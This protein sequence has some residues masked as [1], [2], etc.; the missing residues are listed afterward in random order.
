MSI[1]AGSCGSPSAPACSSSVARSS[2]LPVPRTFTCKFSV[3]DSISAVPTTISRRSKSGINCT[4]KRARSNLAIG[5][6][7]NPGALPILV[8]PTSIAICGNRSSEISPS[9]ISSRPVE[10][11]T[12]VAISSRKSLGSKKTKI[13]TAERANNAMRP[14]KSQARIL[15]NRPINGL[16]FADNQGYQNPAQKSR[17]A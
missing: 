12:A 11:L 16:L 7:P 17:A 14:A 13:A 15:I 8:L 4:R 9:I 3:R 2:Q 1:G 6:P 10:S 5:S